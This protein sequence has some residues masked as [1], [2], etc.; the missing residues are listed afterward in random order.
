MLVFLKLGG[1]LITDKR[2]AETP[3]LD[4]IERLAKEIA[5]ARRADP[6]LHLVIG[7]GSGSFGHVYGRRYGTRE[8]VYDAAGWYGFAATGD[9]AA[10]LNRI[11]TAALLAAEI[12]AWSIQPGAVLRCAEGRIVQGME[13]TVALALARG[14][15]PVVYG[16]VA[17]DR[18]R[19]GTIVSTEEI[20]D[21]LIGVLQPQ[22]VVLAGEVDGIFTND[23]LL[24]PQAQRVAEITPDTLDAIADGLGRSHG[25][26][27]TGGMRAKVLQ[28]MAMVQRHPALEVII[29]SGMAPGRVGGVLTGQEAGTRIAMQARARRVST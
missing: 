2:V 28:A 10:R 21:H 13:E 8:G 15:T 22:R 12:P 5:A 20:F 25:V 18:V 29:C 17:L 27:V 7:H 9:A 11:V 26:D 6:S 3:R 24:D 4:V 19:G 1:S 16:D 14:L 23:P